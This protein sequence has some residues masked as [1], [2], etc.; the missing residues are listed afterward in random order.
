VIKTGDIGELDTAQSAPICDVIP[1]ADPL[2]CEP[3]GRIPRGCRVLLVEDGDTNRRLI[4]KMLEQHGVEVTDAANGQ[5]GVDLAM[6]H[7]FDVILMDMQM[8]VKDGYTAAKELRTKGLRTPIVALTAHAMSGDA[9][10][11]R[12]AGCSDYLSKPIQES[13][14]VN[15]LS[16]LLKRRGESN[17]P[18]PI[19][20]A[21][22]SL[23]GNETI[24]F[25]Q[26]LDL[27]ELALGAI[28]DHVLLSDDDE[29]CCDL[30]DQSA[31]KIACAL[32]L[33]D[34][35]FREIVQE[36]SD[37]VRSQVERMKLSLAAGD[38]NDLV[39]LAH[40]LKGSGGTAGY[41]QFTIPAGR[42]ERLAKEQKRDNVESVLN[43]I[44]RISK[45]VASEMA[46]L[47]TLA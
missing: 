4:H 35:I 15:K 36:F 8:P 23:D 37:K 2:A 17:A 10:K 9:E 7:E 44:D 19:A 32:D 18:R 27:S 22:R 3:M 38:W 1:T 21:P 11:C 39:E 33:N 46:A 43:E 47:P 6:A 24:D 42:L 45:A 5:I 31:V 40:W 25:D 30:S 12:S 14:L 13:R 20:S 26:N 16:E 29:E 28:D 34:E 41:E